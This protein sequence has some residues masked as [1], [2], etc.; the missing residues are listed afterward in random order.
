MF[1]NEPVLHQKKKT[2]KTGHSGAHYTNINLKHDLIS[3]SNDVK[4]KKDNLPKSK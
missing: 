1:Y 2:K 4:Y 3:S